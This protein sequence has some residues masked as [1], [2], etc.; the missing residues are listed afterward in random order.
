LANARGHGRPKFVLNLAPKKKLHKRMKTVQWQIAASL[1]EDPRPSEEACGDWLQRHARFSAPPRG[2]LTFAWDLAFEY[3]KVCAGDAGNPSSY[4][5]MH[6]W[7][8]SAEQTVWQLVMAPSL[9]TTRTCAH[10]KIILQPVGANC[11]P[12]CEVGVLI[13]LEEEDGSRHITSLWSTHP[14]M[15][16]FVESARGAI[17]DICMPC[18]CLASDVDVLEFSSALP[19][20]V[21]GQGLA[22]A[23]Q[24]HAHAGARCCPLTAFPQDFLLRGGVLHRSWGQWAARWWAASKPAVP[25][26]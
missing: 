9:E 3:A 17:C 5:A 6:Y 10:V 1:P 11:P 4:I 14:E 2:N 7:S 16:M 18:S 22:A 25:Q 21:C 20:C 24:R 12:M 13:E 15:S 8:D 19:L 23:A 26:I